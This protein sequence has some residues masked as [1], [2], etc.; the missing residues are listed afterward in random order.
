MRLGIVRVNVCCVR[1][2]AVGLTT[3]GAWRCGTVLH[4]MARTVHE[5]GLIHS[6]YPQGRWCRATCSVCFSH[7]CVVSISPYLRGNII[8][9]VSLYRC[10]FLNC[11]DRVIEE[12]DYSD[13]V[14]GRGGQ[15]M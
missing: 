2:R 14:L 13:A 15:Y 5:P 1:L 8:N 4:P 7:D 9:V 12:S 3:G 10:V 6:S 11:Q